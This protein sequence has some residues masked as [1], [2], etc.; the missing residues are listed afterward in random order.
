MNNTLEPLNMIEL[1]AQ[2]AFPMA[3]ENGELNWY[4]PRKR[5]IIPLD[6]YNIPRSLKQTMKKVNFKVEID[7]RTMAVVRACAERSPT[8]I[9]EEL[10]EGYRGLQKMGFLHSVEVYDNSKLVGGLYGV[11]FRGAFFGESMF[12]RVSQ[13]SKI[14]LAYLLQRLSEK[15]FVVLDVQFI[16][17]HLKMFGAV[18]ISFE[19][20]SQLLIKAYGKDTGFV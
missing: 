2:G 6:N 4:L 1:Y 12:S 8:W 20:Y 11:A 16:T 17:E 19:E 9:S 13:A 5:A 10:I 7:K 14:A 15:G 3:D 18:E